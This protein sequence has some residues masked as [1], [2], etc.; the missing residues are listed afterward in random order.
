[1][2]SFKLRSEY[3]EKEGIKLIESENLVDEVWG[4]N[5]PPMPTKK[6]WILEEKYSG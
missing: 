2:K 6:A 5:K 4:E 3:L 1:M